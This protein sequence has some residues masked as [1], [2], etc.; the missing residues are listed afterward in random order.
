[1]QMSSSQKNFQN[2]F[3]ILIDS[4]TKDSVLTRTRETYTGG[5]QLT[6]TTNSGFKKKTNLKPQNYFYRV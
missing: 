5:A 1:M 3:I 6:H 2:C 4:N